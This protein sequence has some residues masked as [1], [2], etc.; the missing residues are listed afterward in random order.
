MAEL[1]AS[2]LQQL[3]RVRRRLLDKRLLKAEDDAVSAL[4]PGRGRMLFWG[5]NDERAREIPLAGEAGCAA[6]HG[7]VYRL[8]PDIGAVASVSTVTSSELWRR[9]LRVPIVFDEQARHIGEAWA[10]VPATQLATVLAGGA[11]AG[12]VDGASW[13]WA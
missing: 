10:G 2:R 3:E 12:V 1:A 11:N 7:Q 5:K 6:L 13:C 8:R 9:Y 4:L